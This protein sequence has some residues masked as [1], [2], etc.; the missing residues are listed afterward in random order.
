MQISEDD[1]DDH[2]AKAKVCIKTLKEALEVECE[3]GP[4]DQ[5]TEGLGTV[6]MICTARED[7][8][9]FQF[10]QQVAE[11]I[12]GAE[13]AKKVI[14]ETYHDMTLLNVAIQTFNPK[15]LNFILSLD[16]P[17]ELRIQP[18]Q[19]DNELV[20]TPKDLPNV[21]GGTPCWSPV[22]ECLLR[23]NVQG[24]SQVCDN[25]LEEQKKYLKLGKILPDVYRPTYESDHQTYRELLFDRSCHTGFNDANEYL[26]YNWHWNVV[27]LDELER[28][29]KNDAEIRRQMQEILKK[30][31]MKFN[32]N[33]SE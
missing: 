25:F 7:L 24:L 15:V 13:D 33:Q 21:A 32:Q 9:C 28:Q 6:F 19:Q 8:D 27:E 18:G 22:S 4:L 30:W 14:A 20:C 16:L 10:L 3:E 5:D 11:L 23:G 26:L 17:I 31:E 1:R 12:Y 2:S 29:N